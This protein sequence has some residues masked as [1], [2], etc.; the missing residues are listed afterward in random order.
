MGVL[1]TA[2][3]IVEL[4]GAPSPGR[5]A[6]VADMRSRFEARTGAF[7]PDDPWFE[8]RSR[9]FW[10]D[11]ITTQ[12]FGAEVA[13]AL[14]AAEAS[15]LGPLERAHRG[16]FRV[17]GDGEVLVDTWSGA[18]LIV[19]TM[20]EASRAE[21]DASAGQLFDARVVGS[22]D[23]FVVALLPGAVFHPPDATAAIPPVLA[24]ARQR[25]LPAGET[26][27]ALL[28]MQR[29]LRSL[30]RV[31]AAYAY[32]VEALSPHAPALGGVPVRRAD[33]GPK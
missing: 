22:S 12:R 15:W 24:A 19:D 20:D 4:G 6:R 9:A 13:D 10:C 28:R 31:K 33:K 27:D 16:L 17:G 1:E 23:P 7:A 18:E 11:A 29:T 5:A 3:R 21:L 2:A 25:A 30:S 14:T 8:E 26:L 32:R